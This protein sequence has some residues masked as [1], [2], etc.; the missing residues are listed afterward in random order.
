MPLIEPLPE[1]L[2]AEEWLDDP[3]EPP[4]AVVCVPPEDDE[5]VLLAPLL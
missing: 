4:I 1:P 3:E 2:D 5:V